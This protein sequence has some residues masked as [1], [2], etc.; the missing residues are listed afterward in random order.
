MPI[1]TPA[2]FE[3]LGVF[4]LGRTFDPAAPGGRREASGPALLYDARDLTTHA[5]CVGMTGSGK[6]GLCISLLEEAA[7]DGVPAICIDPKGDIGNLLLTFPGLRPEDFA[8]WI[9]P[10]EATRRGQSTDERARDVA[11]AWREGLAAWGQ[12][13]ARIQKL[14]ETVDLAIYTPGSTSGR[15]LSVVRTLAPPASDDPET[16]RDAIDAMVSGLLALVGIEAD[17]I[18]SREHVFLTTL[19]QHVFAEGR[20]LDLGELVR[21]ILEP[22]L[23]RIGVLDLE[24]FFGAKDR[25]GLALRLNGLLASAGFAAWLEGEPLDV[26][27]LLYTPEGKPRVVVLSIAHLSESERMFFVTLLLGQVLAWMRAQPGTSSLRALLYMDEVFG[28]LPPVREPPSK[29]LFL[30]LLKQARAFGV[31]LVLATQNPVDVDYKALSNC[32]T[33]FLGRLQTERDVDRVIDGLAGANAGRAF[34]VGAVR[35][36]L[37]GLEPRTFLMNDVHEDGPVLFQT[38]WALS[39]LRGPL[40]RDQIR[41]LV[42]STAGPASTMAS[43]ASIATAPAA[44]GA[45]PVTSPAHEATASTRPVLGVDIEELFVGEP[46]GDFDYVPALL[47]TAQLHYVHAK[48]GIDTW[49]ERTILAPLVDG[50]PSALWEGG[51]ALDPQQLVIRDAPLTPR[52]WLPIPRGALT[53]ARQKSLTSALK[54]HLFQTMPLTIGRCT[55]PSLW[56]QLGEGYDEFVA[57]VR[58]SHREARDVE[59]GKLRERWAKKLAKAEADVRRAEER[60][61][62]EKGQVRTAQLDTALGVGTTVLGAIFGRGT[63]GGHASRAATTARKARRISQQGDDVERAEAQ[64]ARASEALAELR[65]A[66]KAD[67]SAVQVSAVQVSAGQAADAVPSIQPVPIAPRKGDLTITRLAFAWVARS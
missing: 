57:R 37:A 1:P 4:Y 63:I 20:S 56:S 43:S 18:Q 12:D 28:F 62:T 58:Q 25:Q 51:Q 65:A 30:T 11:T 34:D 3:K 35:E 45:A 59:V 10:G 52:G 13:G 55:E 32:G 6:T 9:D 47:A 33:W 21:A 39:Y 42:A 60:I 19:L 26:Q 16:Q 64:L 23:T 54:A 61:E 8:P 5:F 15:P 36:M 48:S 2:D 53:S 40:A 49:Y 66:M 31:G 27:R 29:R 24:T 22:P 41:A 14:R 7:I 67:V 17:P 50:T 38:R 44:I 46:R